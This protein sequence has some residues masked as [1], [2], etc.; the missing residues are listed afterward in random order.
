MAE[1][2]RTCRQCGTPNPPGNTF[3]GRCGAHLAPT[4][5]ASPPRLRAVPTADE[6]RNRRNVMII[7]AIVAFF[8]ISCIL[9]FAV[10]IIWRP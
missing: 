6:T 9:L 7:N 1:T 8:V 4:P 3:C 10:V 5:A 2:S